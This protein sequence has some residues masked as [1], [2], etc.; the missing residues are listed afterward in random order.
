MNICFLLY[1]TKNVIWLIC[2]QAD[3]FFIQLKLF[4][5]VML[6]IHFMVEIHFES[7]ED[8]LF[9]KWGMRFFL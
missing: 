5:L 9:K 4:E 7:L 2:N 3:L 6:F 1:V 8:R